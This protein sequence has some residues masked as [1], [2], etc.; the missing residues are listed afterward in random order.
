MTETY[1]KGPF[2]RDQL[3]LGCHPEVNPI[4]SSP[5]TLPG[6]Q[7]PEELTATERQELIFHYYMRLHYLLRLHREAQEQKQGAD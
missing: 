4:F 3:F 7:P 1:K 2:K 6:W 5:G